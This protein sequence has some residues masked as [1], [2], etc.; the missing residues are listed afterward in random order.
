MYLFYRLFHFL[1]FI[2]FSFLH[3]LYHFRGVQI[4]TVY[5]DKLFG[6]SS[7]P[8]DPYYLLSSW[9][10]AP[11]GGRSGFQFQLESVA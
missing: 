9:R 2:L 1:Y 11:L 6:F 8:A 7:L 3:Y 10:T 4:L 5:I